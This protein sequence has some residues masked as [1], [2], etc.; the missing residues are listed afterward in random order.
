MGVAGGPW[1]GGEDSEGQVGQGQ[2]T[3]GPACLA[4]KCHLLPGTIRT[5]S[6]SQVYVGPNQLCLATNISLVSRS[7]QKRPS[8]GSPVLIPPPWGS[9]LW[10][11]RGAPAC[12]S[13]IHHPQKTAPT[14]GA[15]LIFPY[16]SILSPLNH[17]ACSSLNSLQFVYILPGPSCLKENTLFKCREP[18]PRALSAAQRLRAGRRG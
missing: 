7:A 14:C 9:H 3:Q 12:D 13:Q 17:L 6:G 11:V 8:R 2:I 16:K 15:A 4:T 18:A 10:K 1:Q 5:I